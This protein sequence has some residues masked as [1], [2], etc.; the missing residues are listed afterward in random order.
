[1]YAS[2]QSLT[3]ISMKPL[4]FL[5]N[6]NWAHYLVTG[7]VLVFTAYLAIPAF[8]ASAATVRGL[9]MSQ[10]HLNPFERVKKILR[11]SQL[12]AQTVGS[13]DS[14]ITATQMYDN[15][16]SYGDTLPVT[17]WPTPGGYMINPWGDPNAGLFPSLS[18]DYQ[19]DGKYSMKLG[20]NI[21]ASRGYV[22]TG[23]LLTDAPDWSS[24]DGVRF[25]LKPDGSGRTVTFQILEH[26]GADGVHYTWNLDYK[27]DGT[28][29]VVITAPW[30]AFHGD[31][32]HQMDLSGLTE[33]VW[34]I[35]GAPGPGAFYVDKIQLIKTA[36]PLSSMVITPTDGSMAPPVSSSASVPL[37]INAGGS[38]FVGSDGTNW[39]A[40]EYFDGGNTADRGNIAVQG[41]AAGKSDW[42][43]R[44][45]MNGYHIPL[46]NGTY[47]VTLDFAET[48]NGITAPGQRVF[49]ADVEG[50]TIA[51]IDPFGDTGRLNT[52]DRKQVTV[53]VTNGTLDITFTPLAQNAEINGIE[54]L[55]Q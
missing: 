47:K 13:G 44:Y 32:G 11:E 16:E 39:V 54:I 33:Q 27:M 52:E 21:E 19:A 24:W 49:D 53:T 23:H 51:K 34:W 12:V 42:T 31:S 46:A 2:R 8:E 55:P 41:D 10:A 40:D 7:S 45:G 22:G 17:N 15:F 48:Y 29:P 30:S 25:W 37:F 50:T 38:S 6:I 35:G 4:K 9:T 20:Y 28:T 43:E 14:N 18:M 5:S 26:I 1:M 3:G 36:S